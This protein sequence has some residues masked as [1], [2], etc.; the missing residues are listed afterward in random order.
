MGLA[1]RTPKPL[2]RLPSSSSSSS[3]SFIFT[4]LAMAAPPARGTE[5]AVAAQLEEREE[6]TNAET[7]ASRLANLPDFGTKLCTHQ[8]RARIVAASQGAPAET[9]STTKSAATYV[10]THNTAPPP[11]GVVTTDGTN[12]LV[13]SLIRNKHASSSSS[14]TAASGANAR[15]GGFIAPA[16]KRS[17]L[18]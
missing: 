16:T 4:F 14:S 12:V 11:D 13:R 6:E 1:Q 15:S 9:I 2:P 7:V 8:T 5:H 18:S 3:S 17:R 10:C